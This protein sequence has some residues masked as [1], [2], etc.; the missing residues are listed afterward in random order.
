MTAKTPDDLQL[1]YGN[2]VFTLGALCLIIY[3]LGMARVAY[4]V[5]LLG[6][7][8][9]LFAKLLL[10]LLVFYFGIGLGTI[11]Q[12][13]FGIAGFPVFAQFF[14]WAFLALLSLTYLAITFR[15]SVRD[16]SML[17]YGAFLTLIL[18]Q[19]ASAFSMRLVVPGRT[20]GVF[21][22]PMLAIVLFHLLLIVYQYVFAGM[23]LTLHLVGDL[24]FLLLMTV[25]S[26]AMLGQ[27]A[28]RAVI[29]RLIDRI[30]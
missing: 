13:R 23:P 15:V 1:I 6:V 28:F 24:F 7:I 30:G 27:S 29:E 11:S 2:V 14:T 16:Y 21:S 25:I 3:L 26:S 17:L 9:N 10:L 4:D 18:V 8:S 20:I 22:I 19:V 12:R 5:V